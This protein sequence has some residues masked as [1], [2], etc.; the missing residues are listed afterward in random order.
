M[1]LEK[2]LKNY[3]NND[4]KFIMKN[5]ILYMS[6][7]T[8]GGCVSFK[9]ENGTFKATKCGIN[10]KVLLVTEKKSE[11]RDFIINSYQ[12]IHK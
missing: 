6:D 7:T 10:P 4:L 5:D 12:V 2:V 11:M 3:A 8:H 9:Y 1:N